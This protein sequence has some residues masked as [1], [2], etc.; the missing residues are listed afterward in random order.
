MNKAITDGLV[1]AP[2]AFAAGLTVWS[3]EDG[4]PGSVTYDAVPTAAFVPSDTDF[5]GCLELVK[6]DSVQRLR[7]TGETPLLPGC[8]L[9]VTVRDKAISGAFPSVRIAGFAADAGG[10][11]A[12]GVVTTGPS[13]LLSSYGE[14][15]EVSAIIG[16]GARTGVDMVLVVLHFHLYA[17][18]L[19]F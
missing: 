8:Y 17:R 10:S 11:A 16:T 18:S 12:G 13:T 1:L 3:S 6:T 4:T 19:F 14:V 9:R 5:A 15:V 2:P 7:Y